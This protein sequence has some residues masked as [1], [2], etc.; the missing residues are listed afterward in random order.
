[1]ITAEKTPTRIKSYD[2]EGKSAKLIKGVQELVEGCS[3]IPMT[4]DKQ[5]RVYLAAPRKG[6]VLRCVPEGAGANQ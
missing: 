3:Y 4:A 6:L 5:G 2:K 1:M